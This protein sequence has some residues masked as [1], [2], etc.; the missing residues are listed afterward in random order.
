MAWA[1]HYEGISFW[2]PPPIG[3]GI[4]HGD[5]LRGD[6]GGEKQRE[7]TVIGGTVNIAA[8]LC[9]AANA[10]EVIVSQTI[11]DLVAAEF[12]CGEPRFVNLKGLSEAAKIFPLILQ[13]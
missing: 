10:L 6:L 8:R 11:A 7:Y 4:H 9:G 1:R 12:Q 2:N 13:P 3:L 5:F